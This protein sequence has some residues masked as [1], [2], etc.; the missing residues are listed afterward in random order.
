[1][2]DLSFEDEKK[3]KAR[4]ILLVYGIVFVILIVFI[5]TADLGGSDTNDVTNATNNN[6]NEVSNNVENNIVAI[7][8]LYVWKMANYG[9]VNILG[10][11][12]A[13]GT[14]FSV[15]AVKLK[16]TANYSYQKAID[17][18]NSNSKLYKS[19]IPY[20]PLHSGKAA[21][22]ATFGKYSLSATTCRRAV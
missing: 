5:R 16:L 20:T 10:A 14:E 12:V 21:A 8:T 6:V 9:K 4:M 13:A 7:P 3:K 22:V 1:M 11:S 15:A 19:K 17:V 2:N 18:T